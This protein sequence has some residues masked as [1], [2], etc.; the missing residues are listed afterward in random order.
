MAN[1]NVDYSD[2][3]EDENENGTNGDDTDTSNM[4]NDQRQAEMIKHIRKLGSDKGLGDDSL[5]KLGIT[6]LHY[7]SGENPVID[8]NANKKAVHE[9]YD[10]YMDRRAEKRVHSQ[11]SDTRSS[12]IS[13][14]KNF[15]ELGANQDIDGEA[16]FTDVARLYREKTKEGIKLQS[17]YAAYVAVARKVKDM[18]TVPSEE[19]IVEIMQPKVKQTHTL[20]DIVEKFANDLGKLLTG[21]RKDGIMCQDQ[22]II[23]ARGKL[24]EWINKM[25][26]AEELDQFRAGAAKFGVK[27]PVALR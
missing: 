24:D 17:V 5:P 9:I 23:D 7:A 1:A 15:A 12:Q 21:E 19:E 2:D 8:L 11:D 25:V 27:L 20:R 26:L 18:K 10:V 13:K 22:E 6:V 16:L 4:A 3:Y 14:L